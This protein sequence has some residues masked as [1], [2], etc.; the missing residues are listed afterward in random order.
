MTATTAIAEKARAIS[1]SR[2]PRSNDLLTL[3]TAHA[4]P[5]FS[6]IIQERVV[7]WSGF[8]VFEKETSGSLADKEVL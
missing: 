1:G 7:G 4:N 8:S 6:P 2:D 3:V 5:I